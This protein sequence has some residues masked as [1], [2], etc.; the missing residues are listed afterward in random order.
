MRAQREAHEQAQRERKAIEAAKRKAI[1]AA[2]KSKAAERGHL[3]RHVEW[4]AAL[5]QELPPAVSASNLA[6]AP[7]SASASDDS[8]LGLLLLDGNGTVDDADLL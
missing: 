1:E 7:T 4:K 8:M 2:S 6:P 3:D 5:R